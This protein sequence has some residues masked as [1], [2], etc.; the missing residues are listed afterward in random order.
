MPGCGTKKPMWWKRHI[1]KDK[2][3]QT[4]RVDQRDQATQV[5][6]ESADSV[7]VTFNQA[8]AQSTVQ[9]QATLSSL[10]SSESQSADRLADMV[11]GGA[12]YVV[13]AEYFAPGPHGLAP[14]AP[15]AI[16]D[17]A[18]PDP[19]DLPPD[20]PAPPTNRMV[21]LYRGWSTHGGSTRGTRY[22]ARKWHQQ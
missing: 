18:V 14:P 11:D 19:P 12:E 20:V 15:P 13:Y 3:T 2:E 9:D 21:P 7:Y 22:W 1:M 16:P 10:S 17:P 5:G 4:D 8:T 6:S